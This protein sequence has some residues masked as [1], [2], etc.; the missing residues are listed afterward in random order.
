MFI[1]TA[2]PARPKPK[3]SEIFGS[4]Q[5]IDNKTALAS[6][7]WIPLQNQ[8]QTAIDYYDVTLTGSD[9]P[10]SINIHVA[11]SQ[12]TFSY[13][14]MLSDGNSS[15]ASI[16]AVDVCGQRSEPTSLELIVTNTVTS[17]CTTVTPTPCNTQETTVDILAG[18]L[19]AVI[20]VLI[21][22]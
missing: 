12:Q 2:K 11:A 14:Y 22:S 13:K 4:I 17:N 9:H 5:I 8:N 3:D 16:E 10:Y 7:T 15:E 6:V 21:S 1:Y 18:I 19:A 20:A